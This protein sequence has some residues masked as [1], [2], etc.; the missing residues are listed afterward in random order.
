MVA[1]LVPAQV[2]VPVPVQVQVQ[3][4]AIGNNISV[5]GTTK[6]G[7]AGEPIMRAAVEA[8]AVAHLM[9]QT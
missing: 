3:D 9:H 7:A 8:V 5:I 6:Q 1:T 4:T 2:Q